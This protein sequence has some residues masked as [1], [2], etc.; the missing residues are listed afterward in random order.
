MSKKIMSNGIYKSTVHRAVT[1]SEKERVS[2]A[3]F[4]DSDRDKEIGPFDEL[5]SANYHQRYKSISLKD[6]ANTFFKLYQSGKR[7]IDDVKV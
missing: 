3:A 2:I 7:P 4:W 6:Y 5:V 1:N